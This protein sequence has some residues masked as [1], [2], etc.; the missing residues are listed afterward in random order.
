MN[1]GVL[2]AVLLEAEGSSVDYVISPSGVIGI[3]SIILAALVLGWTLSA[4]M[5]LYRKGVAAQVDQ[6]N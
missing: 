3:V 4:A 1:A 6:A 5:G 2:P